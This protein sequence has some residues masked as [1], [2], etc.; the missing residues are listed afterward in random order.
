M[1]KNVFFFFGLLI[2]TLNSCL[3]IELSDTEQ[4][5]PENK[6]NSV[7]EISVHEF[8]TQQKIKITDSNQ[9]KE[10]INVFKDSSNYFK[11]DKVEFNGVKPLYS[12]S[13]KSEEKIPDFQIYPTEKNEKLEIAYFENV[14]SKSDKSSWRYYNRFYLN[15][16]LISIIERV[17]E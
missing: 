1:K 11:N 8:K 14:E 13:F 3:N 5:F 9:I 17:T 7:N 15:T 16:K 6:F 10:I 4:V 2:L 12:L